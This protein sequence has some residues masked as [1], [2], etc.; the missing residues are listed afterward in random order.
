MSKQVEFGSREASYVLRKDR[1]L[2][3]LWLRAAE[4]ASDTASARDVEGTQ[5]LAI[6]FFVDLRSW[7]CTSANIAA[8]S[9][10]Q[11]DRIWGR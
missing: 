8:L 10:W 11:H 7:L 5:E 6:D 9:D 4:F 2:N 3:E 1:L